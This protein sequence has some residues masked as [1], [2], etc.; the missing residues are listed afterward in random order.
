MNL[1]INNKQYNIIENR[2]SWNI[3]NISEKME[4]TINVSKELCKDVDEVK[5]YIK[6]VLY[7]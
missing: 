2:N 4:V 7:G 3:K 6:E 5:E 1:E